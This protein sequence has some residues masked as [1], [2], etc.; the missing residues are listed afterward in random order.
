M[1]GTV[2]VLDEDQRAAVEQLRG[3]LLVSAPVGSG[4]TTVL[5][6]RLVHAV[7]AGWPPDRLLCLTFTN[8]AARSIQARLRQ[9]H[10]TL[11]DRVVLKTFH[12]LCADIVRREARRIG[13]PI[14]YTICDETDSLALF[15]R[16]LREDEAGSESRD[17]YHALQ[18]AKSGLP[19]ED[20]TWPLDYERCWAGLRDGR[21]QRAARR[22]QEA[23]AS[24]QS[25]DFDDLVLMVRAMLARDQD[26]RV[27]WGRQ[28]DLVQVDEVQDTQLSEFE[29]VE[30]LAAGA[31]NLALFG[32]RNQTIYEWRGASPDA[33]LGRFRALYPEVR[34]I[35][36]RRNY[37]STRRIAEVVATFGQTIQAAPAEPAEEAG[38]PG[39]APE[40]FV[41][42]DVMDEGDWI[43]RRVARLLEEEPGLTGGQIA[44]LGRTNWYCREIASAFDHRGVSHLTVEHDE[45]FRRREIKD[46][47]AH[48]RLIVNP[49]DAAAALRLW[50]RGSRPTRGSRRS[51]SALNQAGR[52]VGLRMIDYL[53]TDTYEYGEP[54]G[55]LTEAFRGGSVVVLDVES[56]GLS[57]LTDDVIEV[58]ATRLERGRETA[59]FQALVRNTIPVGDSG[60]VHGLTDETL[61][62]HGRDAAEVFT[63]LQR[64]VG[65]SLLVGHN[66]GFDL[67]LLVS[68]AR[69]VGV[70]LNLATGAD[71]LELA[72]RFVV[73]S[74]YTL[75]GIVESLGLAAMP[76][77]RATDDVA[78]TT[79]LLG[80][81]VEL[82]EAQ[83][84]ARRALVD[85]VGGEY[86]RLATNL[87]RWRALAGEVRPAEL[88]DTILTEWEVPEE[89]VRDAG[90]QANLREL[91]ALFAERDRAELDPVT[92]LREL[93]A[94][95]A[96][97]RGLDH[98][99]SG[100]GRVPII[101]IHQSKG[102]EFDVVF[103]AGCSEGILPPRRSDEPGR[104]SEE[105]RLF[106]VALTRARR[107]LFLT[108]AAYGSFGRKQVESRFL[109]PIGKLVRPAV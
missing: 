34:E 15:R 100:D 3:G 101:T 13:V 106:Y 84:A 64:F 51:V 57:T 66:V 46:A 96:L 44:V 60:R 70:V 22:Y 103:V 104:L 10:G 49:A 27:R 21:W 23:L 68:H 30:A 98:V 52:A 2:T 29:V 82:A 63:E 99:E 65:A 61:A 53:K 43:A 58:A 93:V 54:M 16:M 87:G 85:E 69:R 25:L 95:A 108:R 45:F 73:A 20:L 90:R 94:F 74:D 71:T 55:R 72:R 42:Q 48:L 79:A 35:V 19:R 31:G 83:S 39:E 76:T 107:R 24:Y 78:A 8:R 105:G 75:R 12:T 77:H 38:D 36:L 86:R 5:T 4:K 40:L 67:Q 41:A 97:A 81:L 88:L 7:N 26:A 32:D 59:Q 62:E 50:E 56:T 17:L 18:K 91:V 1:T 33:L 80:T 28:F 109:A 47:V 6:E 102:L 9:R 89:D 11:A 92:A 37:R 14:D